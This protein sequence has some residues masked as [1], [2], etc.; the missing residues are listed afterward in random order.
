[1]THSEHRVSLASVEVLDYFFKFKF[2]RV[3]VF[4]VFYVV[5]F[6]STQSEDTVDARSRHPGIQYYPVMDQY[7][8]N[9]GLHHVVDIM[10][11][12]T[13]AINGSL[14]AGLVER[15][16]PETQT[17]HLPFGE[18]TV[19]LQ[20]VSVLWGL[21]IQG[22]PVGGISDPP[23]EENDMIN[24]RLAALLGAGG[25]IRDNSGRS[26]YNLKKT[27]LRALFAGGLD[28]HATDLEVQRYSYKLIVL[29]LFC[30]IFHVQK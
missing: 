19:T 2:C 17:F 18:M 22:E 27:K 23:E 8:Q 9:L 24:D 7:L 1:M 20:D 10:E 15:W 25:D 26:R 28:R 30:T 5:Y 13:K 12:E 4:S 11:S 21:P 14:I 29:H 6:F 16:R 3:L